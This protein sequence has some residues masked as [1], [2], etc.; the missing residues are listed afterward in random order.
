MNALIILCHPE[1]NSFNGA[2]ADLAKI[3]LEKQGYSVE[4]ADL[5]GEGFAACE[6]PAHYTDR[7]S[8]KAFSALGE[9]RHAY[10]NGSLPEDVKRHIALLEKAD[11]VMFQFPIWW[12]STP[13]ILKGWIDRVFVSG[14]LYTSSK[15]YNRGHFKG[16]KT[17][18]SATIGA[19]DIALG[20]G[21]RGGEIDQLFWPTQYS[22]H[23]MGFTILSP[24]LATS[25]QG[26]GYA[27]DDE[28]T[29]KLRLEQH[30]SNLVERLMSLND[31]PPITY[32]TWKDWDA[33]GAKLKTSKYP[34][35]A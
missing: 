23:Y 5:Y 16:K 6:G 2:L 15:R 11:F 12:H 30:K 3:T 14:G 13:A 24:F 32:P 8:T 9:Q 7:E 1:R 25:V 27:T 18:C 20:P 28:A 22:L 17:M 19:P 26:H 31:T 34:Y 33:L 10:N 4:I 29:N 21:C 35:S